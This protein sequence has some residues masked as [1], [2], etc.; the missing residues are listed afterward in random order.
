MLWVSLGEASYAERG[1]VE[2]VDQHPQ[3]LHAVAGALRMLDLPDAAGLL[4]TLEPYV[5][6][7]ASGQQPVPDAE[8]GDAL[9][10]VIISG[11][12]YMQTAVEPGGDRGRLLAYAHR[13]L[14][15]LGLRESVTELP[16]L[17]SK[18]AELDTDLAI[19]D[20]VEAPVAGTPPGDEAL[21]DAIDGL[22]ACRRRADKNPLG[23]A[24]GY[25]TPGLPLD[26]EFTTKRLGF[27]ATQEPVI[28]GGSMV[29]L[30]GETEQPDNRPRR[31][32]ER[33]RRRPA[34]LYRIAASLVLVLDAWLAAACPRTALTLGVGVGIGIGYKKIQPSIPIAIRTPMNETSSQGQ[35][36]KAETQTD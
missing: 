35:G 29:A 25:G 17:G 9:A 8:R 18:S 7:L 33:P 3:R 20:T 22:N 28:D 23:S 12:L 34:H 4:D 24:A 5:D 1:I 19:P 10:D 21:A 30:I 32:A 13:G 15:T 14:E 6:G 26:R 2:R 36:G 31:E 27:A 11:E 16:T